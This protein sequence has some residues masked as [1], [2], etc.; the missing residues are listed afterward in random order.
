MVY[1]YR[2]VITYTIYLI[3]IT[4]LYR[5]KRKFPEGKE[6]WYNIGGGDTMIIII[7][8]IA[9]VYLMLKAD[10]A[11][12]AKR[13]YLNEHYP[14]GK[15]SGYWKNNYNIQIIRIGDTKYAATKWDKDTN[16]F[17]L[18]WLCAGNSPEEHKRIGDD[19]YTIQIIRSQV[20]NKV[21]RVTVTSRNTKRATVYTRN[22]SGR[23]ESRTA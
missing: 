14:L 21:E 12:E 9:M 16:T 1:L 6:G 19:F 7:G 3:K 17:N 18:C 8:M 10:N 5:V 13:A 22:I 2:G 23:I 20:R 11:A 4:P 15:F